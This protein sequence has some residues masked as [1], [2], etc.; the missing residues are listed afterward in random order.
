MQRAIGIWCQQKPKNP[1]KNTPNENEKWI[2][3]KGEEE[4]DDEAEDEEEEEGKGRDNSLRLFS[5]DFLQ[6]KIVIF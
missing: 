3:G 6:K 2:N 5:S 4:E 1:K